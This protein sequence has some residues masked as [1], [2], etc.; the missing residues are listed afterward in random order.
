MTQSGI[1][2]ASFLLVAQCLNQVPHH[3]PPPS[4]QRKYLAIIHC[5]T[6][7]Y[8]T[9]C[10]VPC[11]S[12]LVLRLSSIF[13]CPFSAFCWRHFVHLF[14]SH[15]MSPFLLTAGCVLGLT[16]KFACS[17][18]WPKPHFLCYRLSGT[19]VFRCHNECDKATAVLNRDVFCLTSV[20]CTVDTVTSSLMS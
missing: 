17:S 18:F 1:E 2:P 7:L 11:L 4:P 10:C 5:Q 15:T 14:A 12:L 16:F 3:V 20:F 6:T 13:F 8:I 19:E 9:C